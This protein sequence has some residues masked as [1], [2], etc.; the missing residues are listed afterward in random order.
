[1]VSP[2]WSSLPQEQAQVLPHCSRFILECSFDAVVHDPSALRSTLIIAGLHYSWNTGN[3]QAYESTFLFHKVQG[4]RTVNDWIE[5]QDA[6]RAAV[7]VRQVLTL[8]FAECC[9]GNLPAA[10]AHFQGLMALLDIADPRGLGQMGADEVDG[11]LADRYLILSQNFLHGLKSRFDIDPLRTVSPGPP[12]D[13]LVSETFSRMHK[14]HSAEPMG[15]E[16]RLVA[17]AKLPHFFAPPPRG[18]KPADIDTLALVECLRDITNYVDRRMFGWDD[19]EDF[20]ARGGPTRLFVAVVDLHVLSFSGKVEKVQRDD[21]DSSNFISSWSGASSAMGL[22][23][24]SVLGIWNAGRPMSSRL[25]CRLVQILKR[26]LTSDRQRLGAKGG[27]DR[28]FWFWKVFTGTVALAKARQA[29]SCG[30]SP[31]PSPPPS[32]SSTS[33]AS[34]SEASKG[35]GEVEAL[36]EWFVLSI[37]KWSK[38]TNTKAWEEARTVLAKVVWPVNSSIEPLAI[39]LWHRAMEA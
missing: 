13:S 4:I 22:Y 12:S 32:L 15:L 39:S 1:M 5:K 8:G 38:A 11:E 34:A 16:N 20:F 33:T 3:L 35:I 18:R 17:L 26:H 10:D 36:E 23:L 24:H 19:R 25:L 7:A 31:S 28:G 9:L 2:P 6:A 37:K 21:K 27:L 30:S 14:A 29:V